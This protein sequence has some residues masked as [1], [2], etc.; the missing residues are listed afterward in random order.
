[1][2]DKWF[3]KSQKSSGNNSLLCS[4]WISIGVA[5]SSD[6]K[7]KLYDIW[8]MNKTRS[9]WNTYIDYKRWFDA[10]RSNEKFYYFDECFKANQY[11]LKKI[12]YLTVVFSQIS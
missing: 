2:Y 1:M 9:Y 7:N 3:I 5:K 4:D 10:I 12:Y 6:T 8:V 11:D